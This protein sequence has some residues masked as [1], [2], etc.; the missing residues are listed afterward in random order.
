MKSN[1]YVSFASFNLYYR[2]TSEVLDLWSRLLSSVPD[3]RLVVVGVA[4]GSTQAALLE[5]MNRA[6]ITHDRI[7]MHSLVSYQEYNELMGTVDFALAPF[8]YN[9]ATTMMD[10]LWNGLPVVAKQ[11]GETFCSRL[12]CS[13]LAQMGLSKLIARD[14]DEYIRIAVESTSAVQKLADLRQSLRQRLEQSP[15][16]DFAGFSRGLE[17]AYRSMWKEW[18]ASH[19]AKQ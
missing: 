2:I 10:C 8:P 15:M 7:S 4:R 9:G 19:Q 11:G 6:G 17:L 18:C 13:V 16:R 1:G 5:R 14:E 3:S 12:G